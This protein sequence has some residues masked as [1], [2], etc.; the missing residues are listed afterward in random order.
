MI[1]QNEAEANKACIEWQS[2][3]RLSDWNCKVKIGR[4]E[5]L[6]LD[7][8]A[9]YCAVFARK[10]ALIKLLDPIDWPS[11]DFCMQDHEISLVH[12]LLHLHL[13]ELEY[14]VFGETQATEAWKIAQE[15]VICSLAP[16]IVSL[17]RGER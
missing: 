3:L 5:A 16:G 1:Y 8:Q 4:R 14:T 17:K 10:D 15:H 7:G 11:D 6:K 9:E 13:L 12:E 2:R